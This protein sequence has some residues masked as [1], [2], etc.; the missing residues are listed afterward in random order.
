MIGRIEDMSVPCAFPKFSLYR[1]VQKRE[2]RET[3]FNGFANKENWAKAIILGQSCCPKT[4]LLQKKTFRTAKSMRSAS[5]IFVYETICA[6]QWSEQ[7]LRTR[8]AQ[9]GICLEPLTEVA[10]REESIVGSKANFA[11]RVAMNL[12]TF[13]GSFGTTQSG[14]RLIVPANVFE[15]SCFTTFSF[16]DIF[17]VVYS[18]SRKV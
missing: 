7:A 13:M 17:K 15:R 3:K 12:Y 1:F 2:S 16:S 14:D 5:S 9:I 8:D 10:C 11:K 6:V 4:V 18:F